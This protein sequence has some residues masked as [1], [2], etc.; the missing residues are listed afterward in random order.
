MRGAA[1]ALPV[2]RGLRHRLRAGRFRNAAKP[3]IKERGGGGVGVRW[4]RPC[5][6]RGP[7]STRP[8]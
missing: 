6:R 7:P 4:E 5:W 8:P 1:G 2:G 3:G